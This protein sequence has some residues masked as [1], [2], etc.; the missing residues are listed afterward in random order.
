MPQT[1]ILNVTFQHQVGNLYTYSVY[2]INC[3]RLIEFL[4]FKLN[5]VTNFKHNYSLGEKFA[6]Y[7][8]I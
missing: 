2:E 4:G 8:T 7:L 3:K 6:T 5:A 1:R